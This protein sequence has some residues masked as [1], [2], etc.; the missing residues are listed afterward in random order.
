MLT[1]ALIGGV[2]FLMLILLKCLQK[3]TQ[4][5]QTP[6]KVT[7]GINGS[8]PSFLQ[9]FTGG[10]VYFKFKRLLPSL[11]TLSALQ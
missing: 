3:N 10:Y 4:Q 5:Q 6:T 2:V 11:P 8:Y 1:Y 7:P 9:S